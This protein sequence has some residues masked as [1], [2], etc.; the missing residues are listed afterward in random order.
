MKKTATPRQVEGE[1]RDSP[2]WTTHRYTLQNPEIPHTQNAT[3][4]QNCGHGII[5]K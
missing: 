5:F 1:R 2:K 3:K 4:L